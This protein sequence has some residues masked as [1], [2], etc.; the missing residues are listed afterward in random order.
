[1]PLLVTMAAWLLLWAMYVSIVNI[2]QEFYSFGWESLL[3]ECGFLAV[4]LGNDE[5]APPFLVLLLFR[6]VAFRLEFG[7]GLIQLRGDPCWRALTFMESHPETQ[8]MPNPLPWFFPPLPRTLH[9]IEAGG[10]SVA[11]LAMPFL[12]FLPQPLATFGALVMIA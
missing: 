3:C 7:A 4:F 12:L 6:W 10:N 8:P 1:A 2:G 9:R 5:V 11:Q